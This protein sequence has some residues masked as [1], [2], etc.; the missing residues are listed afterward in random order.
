VPQEE[1]KNRSREAG[2]ANP[3]ANPRTDLK[4][5]HYES[6][7]LPVTSVRRRNRGP[8]SGQFRS[9]MRVP[10][11]PVGILNQTKRKEESHEG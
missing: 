9:R 10:R 7:R 3:K 4:V 5:G 1:P 8:H 11:N 6:K 2:P